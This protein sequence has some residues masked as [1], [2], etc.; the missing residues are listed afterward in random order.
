MSLQEA[1]ES[2][3]HGPV[4][5]PE[6]L[7]SR[8]QAAR[9]LGVP[10]STIYGWARSGRLRSSVTLGGHLRFAPADLD[11]A[12]LAPRRSSPSKSTHDDADVAGAG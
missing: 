11:T 8:G 7:L 4:G 12:R 10:A 1:S 5:P 2:R 6:R 3:L 9:Y